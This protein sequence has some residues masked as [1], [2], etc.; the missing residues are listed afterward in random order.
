MVRFCSLTHQVLFA[1]Q[2]GCLSV[3]SVPNHRLWLIEI[4]K[5][6]D[7]KERKLVVLTFWVVWH[8]RNKLLHDGIRQTVGEIVSFISG[9]LNEINAIKPNFVLPTHT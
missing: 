1:L 7:D 8:A 4:F 5:L 6:A 2:V 9:Y 3:S